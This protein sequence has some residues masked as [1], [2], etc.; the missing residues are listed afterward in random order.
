MKHKGMGD[1][2]II[3][4]AVQVLGGLLILLFGRRLFW[5]FV[6]V[7]GFFFGVQFGFAFFK[8]VAEWVVLSLSVLAGVVCAGLA[9]LLQRLAVAIAGAFAGG[10]I[11][12]WMAQPA[13]LHSAGAQAVAFI[14]GAL[15][16]AVMLT[17]LFDPVLIL[18]S[19]VFG[20]L[21]ITEAMPLDDM[22]MPLVFG[23]CLV[24][25][26]AVQIHSFRHERRSLAG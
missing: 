14:A 3:T 8:G 21:K 11:A 7:T 15:L 25:G 6:G 19:V 12:L 22:L 9:I 17:V 4:P 1:P 13:G 16:A 23:I 10:M 5:V 18:L 26:F 2:V 20:A 24:L